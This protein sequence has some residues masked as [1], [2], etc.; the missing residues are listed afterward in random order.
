MKMN[1]TNVGMNNV[2]AASVT[3]KIDTLIKDVIKKSMK[4]KQLKSDMK[5]FVEQWAKELNDN[6]AS[7]IELEKLTK[8]T[9]N[10]ELQLQ[11]K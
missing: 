8:Q 6:L 1:T 5:F 7:T 4:I 9:A 11:A 2:T 3:A 10:L